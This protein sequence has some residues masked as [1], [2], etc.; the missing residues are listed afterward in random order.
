MHSLYKINVVSC[1]QFDNKETSLHF[2]N[3]M[4]SFVVHIKKSY[5]RFIFQKGYKPFECI[6]R[7]I[8][9]KRTYVKVRHA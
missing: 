3:K 1:I 7:S 6:R 8:D 9:I 5:D 4:S 2:G